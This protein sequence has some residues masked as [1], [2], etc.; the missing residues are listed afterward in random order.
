VVPPKIPDQSEQIASDFKIPKGYKK[1]EDT[2]ST[3]TPKSINN[4]QEQIKDTD[5]ETDSN[6]TY[7][8]EVN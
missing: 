8:D 7:S 3:D 2:K 6:I 4:Q 1:G 5:E